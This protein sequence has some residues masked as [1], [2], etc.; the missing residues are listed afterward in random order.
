METVDKEFVANLLAVL[1][2]V[3]CSAIG[4][5][6]YNVCNERDKAIFKSYFELQ[7]QAV[8][9]GYAEWKVNYKGE[10]TFQWK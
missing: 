4:I 6:T 7:E 3:I 8:L 10:V 2:F 1:V 9:K 5:I